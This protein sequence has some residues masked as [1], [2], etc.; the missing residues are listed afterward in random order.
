M[1][2]PFTKGHANGNDFV[3]VYAKSFP[4]KY[5][6]K[7]VIRD[8]CSRYTGVGA[9]GFFIISSSKKYDFELDYYNC[10]GS[11]ETFCANG[12]RCAVRLMYDNKLI[13]KLVLII[14]I[15]L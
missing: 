12:S 4:K 8:I 1:I 2:I 11:A 13:D 10:D 15:D 7:N 5:R 14:I 9:D 3:F 6:T